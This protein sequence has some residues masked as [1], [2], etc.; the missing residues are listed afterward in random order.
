[1]IA[2][3]NPVETEGVYPLPEAQLDRF[4]YRVNMDYLTPDLELSMLKKKNENKTKKLEK[5]DRKNILGLIGMH[6]Q[7]H[8]DESILKYISNILIETRNN[9][10]LVFGAS[11]RAGEHLLYA[12]KAYA[13]INGREYVIPDDVKKVVP[14]VLGHRIILSA[15]SEFEG[16]STMKIIDDMLNK[17]DVS[18]VF[19]TEIKA[20]K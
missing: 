20:K 17:I 18:D 5:T 4:L 6:H 14:K 7:I 3:K 11:P 12:S 19:E 2:T 15:E 9:D 16:L 1:M 13:L 8:A 10:K